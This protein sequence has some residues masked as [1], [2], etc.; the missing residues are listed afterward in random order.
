MKTLDHALMYNPDNCARFVESLGLKTLFAVLMKGT[1][2]KKGYDEK[3][4]DGN[5]LLIITKIN[6]KLKKIIIINCRT[7]CIDNGIIS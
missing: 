6:S 4:D 7:Y 1:K 2:K 5:A 3:K